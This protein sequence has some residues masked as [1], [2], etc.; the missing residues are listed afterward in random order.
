MHTLSG[1]RAMSMC[2]VVVGGILDRLSALEAAQ[3]SLDNCQYTGD[4]SAGKFP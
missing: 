2:R 4:P 1:S 3:K